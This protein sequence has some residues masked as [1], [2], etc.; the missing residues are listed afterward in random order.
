[1][2]S[3]MICKLPPCHQAISNQHADLTM[4][5]LQPPSM[6]YRFCNDPAQ[7]KGQLIHCII[8]SVAVHMVMQE[9]T[10]AT[11]NELNTN[12]PP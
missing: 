7:A 4:L 5:P 8:Q 11:W 9:Y 10:P 6:L 1:M 3:S 12:Q 2:S